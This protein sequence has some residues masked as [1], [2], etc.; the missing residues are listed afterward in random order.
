MTMSLPI[1]PSFVLGLL[2]LCP[3]VAPAKIERAVWI[4]RYAQNDRGKKS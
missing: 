3:V 2:A 1:L 4:V